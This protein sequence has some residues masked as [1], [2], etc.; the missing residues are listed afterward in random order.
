M[1]KTAAFEAAKIV[2]LAL[3]EGL[4]DYSATNIALAR[5][6]A[7]LALGLLEDLI[8]ALGNEV[9]ARAAPPT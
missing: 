3:K 6:D 4:A 1:E 7:V 5:D 9:R 8:D 2:R